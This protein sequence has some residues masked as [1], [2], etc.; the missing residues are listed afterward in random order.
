M[1]RPVTI[2]VPHSLGK[3][4]ARRRLV[5]GLGKAREEFGDKMRFVEEVWTDDRLDFRVSALG[6]SVDGFLD[7]RDDSVLVEVNLPWVLAM[8]AKKAEAVIRARGT[9]LLGKS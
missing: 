2:S 4:E 1:R 3:E 9:L 8:V 6:Q 7:V 5:T